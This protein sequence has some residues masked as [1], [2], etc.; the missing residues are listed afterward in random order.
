MGKDIILVMSSHSSISVKWLTL[1]YIMNVGR[2]RNNRW[3]RRRRSK[4]RNKGWRC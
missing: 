1:E 3:R 2:S 4:R